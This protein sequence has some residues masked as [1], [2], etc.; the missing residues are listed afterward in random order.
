MTCNLVLYEN[1]INLYLSVKMITWACWHCDLILEYCKTNSQSGTI[2]FLHL[3]TYYNFV[4]IYFFLFCCRINTYFCHLLWGS[5]IKF[6]STD[7]AERFNLDDAWI[8][9]FGYTDTSIFNDLIIWIGNFCIFVHKQN[10][11]T[12]FLFVLW[13]IHYCTSYRGN[14]VCG[15]FHISHD[16]PLHIVGVLFQS[17]AWYSVFSVAEHAI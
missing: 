17:R 7:V 9:K 10:V 15:F 4:L 11:L 13:I 16:F 1:I 5:F 8:V 14:S 3:K 2:C 12:T 6:L